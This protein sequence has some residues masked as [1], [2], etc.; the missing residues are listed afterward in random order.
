M[1]HGIA[2]LLAFLGS[3]GLEYLLHLPF[4]ITLAVGVIALAAFESIY[5]FLNKPKS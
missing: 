3:V 2:A 1:A 4:V 5:A